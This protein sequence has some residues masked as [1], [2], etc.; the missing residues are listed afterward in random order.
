MKD[1]D[2]RTDNVLDVYVKGIGHSY[3]EDEMEL[4]RKINYKYWRHLLYSKELSA[5]LT[6]RRCPISSS[7]RG[8]SSR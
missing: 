4:V 1:E 6:N 8:T 5:L 3:R 7:T 2:G